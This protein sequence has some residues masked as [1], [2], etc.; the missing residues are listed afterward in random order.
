MTDQELD[1]MLTAADDDLQHA[2]RSTLDIDAGLDAIT[3]PP[4]PGFFASAPKS[5][6]FQRRRLASRTRRESRRL[7]G[8][9]ADEP[10]G[11]K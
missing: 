6:T 9:P 8:K 2:I 5:S 7:R 1:A 3:G 10:S 11:G 4:V